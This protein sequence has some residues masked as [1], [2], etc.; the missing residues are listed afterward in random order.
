[1]VLPLLLARLTLFGAA[2]VEVPPLVATMGVAVPGMDGNSHVLSDAPS[3]ASPSF[4]RLLRWFLAVLIMTRIAVA[5]SRTPVMW[6]Y[7]LGLHMLEAAYFYQEAWHRAQEGPL[8]G[9]QKALLAILVLV[10]A[11]LWDVGPGETW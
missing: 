3:K 10:P 8:R 4:R 6:T 9:D 1:M 11:V 5:V 2:L 7:A